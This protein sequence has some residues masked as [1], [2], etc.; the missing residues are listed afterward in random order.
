ML[1]PT[2]CDPNPVSNYPH[3][4]GVD[5]TKLIHNQKKNIF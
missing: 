4:G 1:Q 5:W 2:Y 3:R